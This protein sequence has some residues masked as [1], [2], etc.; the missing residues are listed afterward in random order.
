MDEKVLIAE[1]VTISKKLYDRLL[2]DSELLDALRSAG[3]DNWDG[4]YYACQEVCQDGSE[5]LDF[6]DPEDE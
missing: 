3:V 1:N 6:I 4:Y 2:K 5:D